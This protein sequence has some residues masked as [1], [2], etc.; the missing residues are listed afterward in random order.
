MFKS[1]SRKMTEKIQI[2]TNNYDQ[3]VKNPHHLYFLIY[4]KKNSPK[5]IFSQ[6]KIFPFSKFSLITTVY[7]K[8]ICYAQIRNLYKSCRLVCAT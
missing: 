6:F 5:I 2:K 3:S 1:L 7:N 4:R 8:K